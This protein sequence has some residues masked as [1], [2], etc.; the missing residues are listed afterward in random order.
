M[1]E[2]WEEPRDSDSRFEIKDKED[3]MERTVARRQPPEPDSLP[4]RIFEQEGLNTFSTPEEACDG[5]ELVANGG[6]CEMLNRLHRIEELSEVYKE[7]NAPR[8]QVLEHLKDIAR[9]ITHVS[10]NLVGK[11]PIGSRGLYSV[12]DR[13]TSAL[14]LFR[15]CCLNIYGIIRCFRCCLE[16]CKY[17]T[18]PLS[19]EKS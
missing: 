14:D 10:E 4:C 5:C 12:G 17:E 13:V 1:R 9:G 3:I 6:T 2:R 11:I 18:L 16:V 15:C 8:T 19:L 7:T